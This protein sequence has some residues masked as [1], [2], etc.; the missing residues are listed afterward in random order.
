VRC[1]ALFVVLVGCSFGDAPPVVPHTASG[2]HLVP[3]SA[4][5]RQDPSAN[6]SNNKV[7]TRSEQSPPSRDEAL[8]LGTEF[9]AAAFQI[10]M[11]K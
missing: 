2:A 5:D 8:A 4:L 10:L 3:S 11:E 7:I 1:V 9:A 6:T